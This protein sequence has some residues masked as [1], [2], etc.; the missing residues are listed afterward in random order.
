VTTALACI[1]LWT[2]LS[3]RAGVLVAA[4]LCQHGASCRRLLDAA[5]QAATVFYVGGGLVPLCALAVELARIRG[6]SGHGCAA[7]AGLRPYLWAQSLINTLLG[8]LLSAPSM[9]AR[10][11]ALLSGRAEA[12]AAASGIAALLS[13]RPV[14]ELV[15]AA[16]QSFRAVRLDRVR[17]EHLL[18]GA[19]DAAPRELSEKVRFSECDAFVSHSWSDPAEAKWAALQEWRRQ[20]VSEHGREPLVWIGAQRARRGWTGGGGVEGDGGDS[21]PGPRRRVRARSCALRRPAPQPAAGRSRSA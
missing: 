20:F 18:D 13:R 2:A 3:A 1:G 17:S 16:A 7:T 11:R 9:R 12:G 6:G 10:A 5:W 14:D 19:S 15:E 8:A 4:R 21:R